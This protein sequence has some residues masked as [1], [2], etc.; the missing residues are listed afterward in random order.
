MAGRY[1]KKQL[2]EMSNIK[3]AI[4]ILNERLNVLNPYAPLASKLRASVRTLEDIDHEKNGQTGN[5]GPF[6]SY[7]EVFD[8]LEWN[9]HRDSDGSLELKK[10]SPAGED[11]VFYVDGMDIPRE[12]AKYA[13]GFDVDEHVELWIAGR[14][15]GGCP[16]TARELVEDAEEI[17]KMLDELAESLMTVKERGDGVTMHLWSD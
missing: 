3:F 12:V 8:A 15:K 14:G 5:V 9:C 7:D 10:Y 16:E 17:Q 2:A 1:T 4:C 11:F 13:S 6:K